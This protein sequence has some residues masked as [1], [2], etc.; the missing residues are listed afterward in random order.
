MVLSGD[1]PVVHMS[2]AEG[3][4]VAAMTVKTLKSVRTDENFQA[5]WEKVQ[6]T[7]NELHASGESIIAPK[8]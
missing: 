4:K 5:F 3:Q 8:A 1:F 2:A 7:A 6:K